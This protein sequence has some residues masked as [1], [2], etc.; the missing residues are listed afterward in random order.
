MTKT[1][2]KLLY[3]NLKIEYNKLAKDFLYLNAKHEH[4]IKEL[5]KVIRKLK[6]DVKKEIQLNQKGNKL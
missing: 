4:M 5:N 2:Y 1:N 6:L 3:E